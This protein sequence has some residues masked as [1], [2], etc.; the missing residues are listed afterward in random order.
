MS[1]LIKRV[2]AGLIAAFAVFLV[3]IFALSIFDLPRRGGS[4]LYTLIIT[5]VAI[6]VCIIGLIGGIG[7]FKEWR[8]SR[9]FASFFL[10]GVVFVTVYGSYNKYI[11]SLSTGMSAYDLASL[12]GAMVLFTLLFNEEISEFMTRK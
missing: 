7:V 2:A 11:A 5:F 8:Y 1:S 9:V 4:V 12:F 3:L 10:F 6:T